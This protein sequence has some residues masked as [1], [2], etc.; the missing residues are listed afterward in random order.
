MNLRKV[1]EVFGVLW[2]EPG[3]PGGGVA[4]PVPGLVVVRVLDKLKVHLDQLVAIGLPQLVAAVQHHFGN[5]GKFPEK[6]QAFFSSWIL[7]G[8]LLPEFL[9]DFFFLNS[10]RLFY[11]LNSCRLYLLPEFLQAFFNSWILAGF[12]Y[13]LNSCRL[14]LLPEFLQAFFTSWILAGFF[15]SWILAGF[16]YFVNVCWFSTSEYIQAFYWLNKSTA[17]AAFWIVCRFLLL[18]EQKGAGF[19]YYFLN[20]CRLSTYEYV[21]VVYWLKKSTAVDASWI[22]CRFLLLE[23]VKHFS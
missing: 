17:V 11:F 23:D 16:I 8:F 5:V 20:S 15:T 7:A 19:L 21:Q 3:V 22:V 10:C 14:F 12:I 13:F 18:N 9:Q 4:V 6:V 2:L 1:F